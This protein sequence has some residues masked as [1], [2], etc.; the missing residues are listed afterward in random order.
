MQVSLSENFGSATLDSRLYATTS[1][2]SYSLGSFTPG[3]TWQLSKQAGATTGAVEI[4]TNFKFDGNFTVDLSVDTSSLGTGELGMRLGDQFVL[5]YQEW[6][7][8]G[9]DGGEFT[10][11]WGADTAWAGLV[12]RLI[13]SPCESPA[14]GPRKS[15]SPMVNSSRRGVHW[16]I[17]RWQFSFGRIRATAA[18]D[19]TVGQP[20]AHL[21]VLDQL[22]IVADAFI[23]PEP[24]SVTLVL[25]GLSIGGVS[26]RRN[27]PRRHAT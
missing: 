8:Q 17:S 12:C 1:S 19:P 20:D 14:P 22:T 16:E 15:I 6:F 21:A 11:T 26:G 4:H 7:F 5:P 9:P 24:T 2:L 13:L 3:A 25:L 27:R 23:I 10:R 18:V